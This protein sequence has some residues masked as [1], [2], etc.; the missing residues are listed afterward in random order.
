MEISKRRTTDHCHLCSTARVLHLISHPG[1]RQWR[2]A[3]KYQPLPPPR[4][5]YT[6]KENQ[7]RA[8]IPL[9]CRW[10]CLPRKRVIGWLLFLQQQVS[11]TVK[12]ACLNLCQPTRRL[13]FLQR[14]FAYTAVRA[15]ANRLDQQSLVDGVAIEAATLAKHMYAGFR[16]RRRCQHFAP[17]GWRSS[18]GSTASASL[19]ATLARIS[20]ASCSGL[21]IDS[22]RH[23]RQD[24]HQ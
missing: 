24:R 16:S 17:S 13:L 21:L 14:S 8:Q 18:P 3:S 6:V 5:P 9:N 7:L 23:D 22:R 19:T 4:D 15:F 20:T 1:G 12:F 10:H 2:I 11:L